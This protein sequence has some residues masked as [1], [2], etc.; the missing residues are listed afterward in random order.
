[1]TAV[2]C[3]LVHGP[4]D[5]AAI[6][7]RVGHADAGA[8]VLFVGTTREVTG[9]L[10]TRSLEYEAHEPL[11]EAQLR[12]LAAAAVRTFALTACAVEH[13]LGRVPVGEA[14]VA[15]ATSAPHRRAAFAAAE[16]LMERIKEG[17]PIWKC[18]E[19]ADGARVWI[20]PQARPESSVPERGP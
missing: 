8:N 6:L 2:W 11:A 18:E 14:S 17:V 10:V 7:D 12:E 19:A 4:I 15:V 3:A 5:A 13:R 20:H 9:E 1:M 16:W